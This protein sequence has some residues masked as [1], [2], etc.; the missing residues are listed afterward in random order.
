MHGMLGQKYQSYRL[1]LPLN[2]GFIMRE[3]LE[4]DSIFS[5]VAEDGEHLLNIDLR[6]KAHDLLFSKDIQETRE[7]LFK[8][9][10]KPLF[11]TLEKSYGKRVLWDDW[12]LRAHAEAN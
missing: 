5:L 1:Q 6:E 7:A 2:R 3:Y 8:S 12:Q 10:I 9:H 4:T 11:P